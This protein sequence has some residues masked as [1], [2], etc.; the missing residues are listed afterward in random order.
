[1]TNGHKKDNQGFP[2]LIYVR[3]KDLHDYLIVGEDVEYLDASD[4]DKVAIYELLE[5]SIYREA[6]ITSAR[7]EKAGNDLPD[8]EVAV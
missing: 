6:S 7:L 8:E 1:M 2:E 3:N 5:V 4:G